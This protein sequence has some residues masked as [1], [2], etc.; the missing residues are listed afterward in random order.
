[1]IKGDG[2][3]FV[4]IAPFQ[5]HAKVNGH[6]GISCKCIFNFKFI[7]NNMYFFL[8]IFAF[9]SSAYC[10]LTSFA[11]V[12]NGSSPIWIGPLAINAD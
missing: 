6:Q 3:P 11:I 9:A 10:V 8:G 4:G 5:W 7:F 2:L 12:H 1:L